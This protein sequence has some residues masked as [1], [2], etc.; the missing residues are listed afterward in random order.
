LV[1][2]FGSREGRSGERHED[3]EEQAETAPHGENDS[4][5]ANGCEL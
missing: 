2:I 1:F 3:D 4:I 5:L